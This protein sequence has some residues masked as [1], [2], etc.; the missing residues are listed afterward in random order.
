MLSSKGERESI[1]SGKRQFSVGDFVSFS[2]SNA[3]NTSAIFV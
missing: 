1:N 3:V 2:I